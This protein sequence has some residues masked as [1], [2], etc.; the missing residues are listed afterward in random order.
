MLS[1]PST[2]NNIK[3]QERMTIPAPER[4][5]PTT[6]LNVLNFML[7]IHAILSNSE[8]NREAFPNLRRQWKTWWLVCLY[9]L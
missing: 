5:F 6:V 1:E 2:A 4:K 9:G 3:L 7:L 8:E